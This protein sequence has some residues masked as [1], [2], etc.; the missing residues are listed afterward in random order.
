MRGWARA[1]LTALAS[2]NPAE[3]ARCTRWLLRAHDDL[4]HDAATLAAL[5]HV[6][7]ALLAAVPSG[8]VLLWWAEWGQYT[9]DARHSSALQAV[10][11]PSSQATAEV[12]GGLACLKAYRLTGDT[13]HLALGLRAADQVAAAAPDAAE[14]LAAA[15]RLTRT[16]GY[17]RRAVAA[18]RYALPTP[19]LPPFADEAALNAWA[20]WAVIEQHYSDLLISPLSVVE[21]DRIG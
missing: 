5:H 2:N 13:N 11:L 21:N 17:A 18:L 1:Q 16:A 3:A 9:G 12:E 7:P 6:A 20:T 4:R 19:T 10:L 8:A 14:L 15:F